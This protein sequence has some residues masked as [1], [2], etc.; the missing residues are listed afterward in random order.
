VQQCNGNQAAKQ[1]PLTQAGD[2]VPADAGGRLQY[3]AVQLQEQLLQAATMAAAAVAA[4][5]RWLAVAVCLQMAGPPAVLPSA[6]LLLL[7]PNAPSAL[8][9]QLASSPAGTL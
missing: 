3:V 4:H 1:C 8:L 6:A 5:E 7:V 2:V 9:P